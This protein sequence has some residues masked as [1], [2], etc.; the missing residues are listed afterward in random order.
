MTGPNYILA[1]IPI[2]RQRKVNISLSSTENGIYKFKVQSRQGHLKNFAQIKVEVLPMRN[3][4]HLEMEPKEEK[5]KEEILIINTTLGTT[6]KEVL[7][8]KKKENEE[9]IEEKVKLDRMAKK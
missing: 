1:E 2:L 4:S 5:N 6:T 9:V 7:E 3:Y 8:V